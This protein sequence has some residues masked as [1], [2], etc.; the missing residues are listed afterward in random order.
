MKKYGVRGAAWA[1]GLV[2]CGLLPAQP[3]AI[4]LLERKSLEQI[5]E[6]DRGFDGV[7]GVAAI[8][9]TT[10]HLFGYHIDSVFPQASVIKIPILIAI[11]QAQQEGRFR[12]SDSITLDPKDS[13]GGSGHLQEALKKG[14]LKLTLREM[15]NAMIEDSDNTATN[16]WIAIL[17]M[18][19]VNGATA[20]LGAKQTRLG[21][22]MMDSA[23]AIRNDENLSTPADMARLVELIYRGRAV[24]RAASDE[25]IAFMKKVHGG[26]A[27]GL[28]LDVPTAS[29]IGEIPGARGETGI[30][31]LEGRPFVLSV[32]G[33]FL[34]DRRSPVPEVTRIVFRYFEKLAASN[35]FGNRLR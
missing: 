12:L 15:V 9:L 22:R 20:A 4:E 5:Q 33:T 25:M 3:T 34:D 27:E 16:K 30:V 1:A 14:P 23:A 32:M 7:L 35:R 21:R 29:K 13:V 26:I 31:Y 28:P 6:F 11:Y 10:G 2:W 17:G 8:D 19:Y 18:E 24:D